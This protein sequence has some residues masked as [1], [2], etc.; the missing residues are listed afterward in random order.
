M[1]SYARTPCPP[2]PAESPPVHTIRRPYPA[3][4]RAPEYPRDARSTKQTDPGANGHARQ[5]PDPGPDIAMY[6]RVNAPGLTPL[7]DAGACPR[8]P[9]PDLRRI[10]PCPH[11]RPK[12]PRLR[13]PST[14]NHA[15]LLHLCS[16]IL[17]RIQKRAFSI[18]TI[19]IELHI[20]LLEKI[21]K[22][23]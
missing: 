2:R 17:S 1:P 8:Q 19:D 7:G 22:L 4:P 11:S 20:M 5:P 12:E 13:K 21:N 3:R 10:C 18:L 23:R 9:P 16:Q 14:K 6:T 15:A